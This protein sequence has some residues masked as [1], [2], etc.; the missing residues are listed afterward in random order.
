MTFGRFREK[1]KDAYIPGSVEDPD[2]Y[3][4]YVYT[5]YED[6]VKPFLSLITHWRNED[7]PVSL[8]K[9]RVALGISENVM[10]TLKS[11][12]EF[13]EALDMEGS[14][15]QLKAQKDIV[16]AI[17]EGHKV[18]DFNAKMH[19]MQLKR[20][21]AGYSKD[22]GGDKSVPQKIEI[23]FTDASLSDEEIKQRAGSEDDE[24]GSS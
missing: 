22:G 13:A 16:K 21:D 12:D 2:K 4:S 6:K 9:I 14:L 17:D 1:M 8:K 5:Q 15:M 7:P 23:T 3:L 11:L 10:R 19:E 18:G 20:F 24:D